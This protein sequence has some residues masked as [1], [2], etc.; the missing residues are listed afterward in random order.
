MALSS[1]LYENMD[2]L[3]IKI[4][5]LSFWVSYILYFIS[6]CLGQNVEN[7]NSE[8]FQAVIMNLESF[9]GQFREY[10]LKQEGIISELKSSISELQSKVS[11]LES[12]TD[13]SNTIADIIDRL[14]NVEDYEYSINA[15]VERL[16]AM[17]NTLISTI[18]QIS[19]T[20]T[21][22]DSVMNRLQS[23]E[24]KLETLD[25]D[26]NTSNTKLDAVDNRTTLTEN[27][28]GN[29]DSKLQS[30]ETNI[31]NLDSRVQT[32]E[33]TLQ[34]AIDSI[35]SAENATE[36]LNSRLLL[37][38][39]DIEAM[40]SRHN[41]TEAKVEDIDN[42]VKSV[43]NTVESVNTKLETNEL[44]VQAI[45]TRMDLTNAS[46]TLIKVTLQ[47]LISY[48]ETLTERINVTHVLAESNEDFLCTLEERVDQLET[49]I[50]STKIDINSLDVA[51]NEKLDLHASLINETKVAVQHNQV[52]I[53]DINGT[54]ESDAANTRT[55]IQEM[56]GRIKL[57]ENGNLSIYEALP[58]QGFW[59]FREKGYFQGF[60]EKGHLFSGIWGDFWV[61]GSR[62]QGAEEKHFRELG[63]KVIFLSG[64]R[65]QRPPPLGASSIFISFS[66]NHYLLC[67]IVCSVSNRPEIALK[68]PIVKSWKSRFGLMVVNSIS[69]FCLFVL[70]LNVPV[71]NFSVMSGRSQR[72][73]GLTSTVGN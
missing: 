39:S 8:M 53:S 58:G 62:E 6:V 12:S 42:R 68:E 40:E 16:D 65:E 20:D 14:T 49:I 37:T 59:G 10:T 48:N 43:E 32:T 29:L 18:G 55:T 56:D 64:S 30:V 47:D 36:A 7:V 33:N 44:A 66:F 63:R 22:L 69:Y 11:E 41:A 35:G 17:N 15:I 67:I 9:R 4:N 54:V 27:N 28:I 73:L 50:N 45:N 57:L 46:V 61:L 3:N 19:S 34:T 21:V 2:S 52:L 1:R 70:R 5:Y 60:G 71:N 23:I 51:T 72:F 31:Q 24:S 13:T 25:N 26:L 38:K